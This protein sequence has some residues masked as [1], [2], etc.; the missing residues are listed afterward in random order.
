M[1]KNRQ[2]VRDVVGYARYDTP[3]HVVWLNTVYAL[4]DP[5]ANLL[6]PSRKVVAK[7]RNG[8]RVRKRYDTAR[9]PFQR[10]CDVG[11]LAPSVQAALEKARDELNPMELHRRL[12]QL[13]AS[14]PGQPDSSAV[15]SP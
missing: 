11:A 1:S 6:L 14:P 5:Y 7:T 8:S 13:I 10:L 15:G 4:L 2:F 3:G 9:P 12:E